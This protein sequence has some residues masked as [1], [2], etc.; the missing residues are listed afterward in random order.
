MKLSQKESLNNH[1]MCVHSNSKKLSEYLSDNSLVS[2]ASF[3]CIRYA[4]GQ[5]I[6]DFLRMQCDYTN[7][8]G[9]SRLIPLI[10]TKSI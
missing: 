2:A 7:H 3:A 10:T 9:N 1:N 8:A 4:S 6:Q 5:D